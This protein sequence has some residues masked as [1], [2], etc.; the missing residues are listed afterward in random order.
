[1]LQDTLSH[2]ELK[3]SETDSDLLLHCF[4]GFFNLRCLETLFHRLLHAN[5][6][7]E[8]EKAGKTTWHAVKHCLT[9]SNNVSGE[10]NLYQAVP[11]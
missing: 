6:A 8:I 1:V 3:R 7:P 4:S 9:G 10:E 11:V 2:S 5:M